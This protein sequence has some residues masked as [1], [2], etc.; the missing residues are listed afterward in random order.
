MGHFAWN[1]YDL[2]WFFKYTSNWCHLF[3]HFRPLI[4][5][6]QAMGPEVVLASSRSA[7]MLQ[8]FFQQSNL[9]HCLKF[10]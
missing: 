2:I 3:M 7:L 1:K 10:E 9:V 6:N 4:P 8:F 5:Y